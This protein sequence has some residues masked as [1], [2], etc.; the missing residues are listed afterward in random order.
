M[1]RPE[2]LKELLLQTLQT[3][4]GLI[5]TIK[6]GRANKRQ[7]AISALSMAKRDLLSTHPQVS[8]ITIK[9]VPG[10]PDQIALKHLPSLDFDGE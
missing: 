2:E 8:N 5:M 6:G 3:P 1:N 9:P 10:Q 4:L 7:L